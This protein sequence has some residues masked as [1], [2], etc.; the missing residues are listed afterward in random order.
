MT[1]TALEKFKKQYTYGELVKKH[2]MNEYGFWKI[3]GADNNPDF[4]GTHYQ[5]DLGIYEGKLIDIINYAVSLEDFWSW[6]SGDIVKVN[7]PIKIDAESNDKRSKAEMRIKD[8]ELQ[9]KHAT[10]DLKNI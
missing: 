2:T 10:E 1:N 5:A 6:A 9:L 8:L 4:N 3:R 7:K